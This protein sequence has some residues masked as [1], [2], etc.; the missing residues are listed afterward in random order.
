[1]DVMYH[2]ITFQK[3]VW[4]NDIFNTITYKKLNKI[5]QNY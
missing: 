5:K 3:G 2:V 1:M 4:K